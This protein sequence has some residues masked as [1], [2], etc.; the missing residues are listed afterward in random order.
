MVAPI[1]APA[2]GADDGQLKPRSVRKFIIKPYTIRTLSRH[3]DGAEAFEPLARSRHAGVAQLMVPSAND[4]SQV[5]EAQLLSEISRFKSSMLSQASVLHQVIC[6]R[7]V[8][9]WPKIPPSDSTH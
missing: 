9:S 5:I 3:S 8:V 6:R 7:S 4:H 1:A 2:V